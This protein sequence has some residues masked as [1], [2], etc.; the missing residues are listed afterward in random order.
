MQVLFSFFIPNF[1]IFHQQRCILFTHFDLCVLEAL[2]IE[3]V[4]NYGKIVFTENFVENG[5]WGNASLS[6]STPDNGD[7]YHLKKTALFL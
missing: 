7:Y 4:R 5:W 3:E 1:D 6:G 2:V